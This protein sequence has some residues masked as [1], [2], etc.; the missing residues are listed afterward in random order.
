MK[1]RNRTPERNTSGARR[2]T[3]GK[4][5]TIYRGRGY[6]KPRTQAN[7]YE[8]EEGCACVFGG[9]AR[10]VGGE[11]ALDKCSEHLRCSG[12]IHTKRTEV[13]GLG[14]GPGVLTCG[15]AEQGVLGGLDLL[16]AP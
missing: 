4:H 3:R 6:K 13:Q 1:E 5:D 15:A 7:D 10:G 16:L 14:K 2:R 11:G 9:G 12:V 8:G